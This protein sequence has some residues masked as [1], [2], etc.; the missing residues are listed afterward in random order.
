MRR[1]KWSHLTLAFAMAACGEQAVTAVGDDDDGGSSSGG[2]GDS[3]DGNGALENP[4]SPDAPTSDGSTVS[5]VPG[6]DECPAWSPG[7]RPTVEL[8]DT[9]TKEYELDLAR[10]EI[11]N[12]SGDP[13]ETRTRMN[14]A[15]EWA[16][17]N[18]FD[19]VI[20][21]AGTYLV[22]EDTNDVYSAG[23]EL[24][25]NM[26]LELADGAKIQMAP[27][28][29]WN[30]CVVV[31][32]NNTTIRGGI[33]EG[34][35]AD[36]TYDEEDKGH[37]EGHGVCVWTAISRVLIE[38]T[39]LT[40]LTG[41]GVLIVGRKESDTQAETPT[42]DVTIRNNNI[43]H[44]RRQGVSIV[45]GHRVLIENNQIHHIEGTAPQF[46]VDIEGA[47]REDRDIHIFRNN[48]HHNA[49]GDIVTS[50]GKNVWI[51]ENTLTQCR[52]GDDGKYDPALPC[53]LEKQIDAPIILWKETDN[54][55]LN[56]SIRMAIRTVNGF[57]GILGY[58]KR[59]GPTRDNPV[60]NYIAGNTFY[61]AG[62]HMAYN[63]RTVLSNNTLNEGMILGFNLGCT[64]LEDNRINRTQRENY[65]LRNVAG[66]ASG[67]LLNKSEGAPES[68]DQEM[69]FPMANDAPYRNSSPVFW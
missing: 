64:R 23:I 21:P 57:W 50:T 38:D 37:D 1:L 47:G 3:G 62:I 36:H 13:V 25:E 8:P 69:H 16:A 7:E 44:N 43:H 5:D 10:W 28:D 14:E 6:D 67:N 42:T 17:A 54:V 22:G 40:E 31:A 59:D 45:G 24:V 60:G 12:D 61:D 18:D 11:D 30:Y 9:H 27:N 33:I 58:T 56:N 49:G 53:L 26:T 4:I 2:D 48:F 52:V 20:V 29:R 55:V 35:R 41:D 65:K 15:I 63:S 32:H 34:D 68:D 46:G 66:V 39:E 51:E 19:K